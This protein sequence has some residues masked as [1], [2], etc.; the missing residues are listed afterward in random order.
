M[1]GHDLLHLALRPMRVSAAKR[2]RRYR[3]RHREQY[4]AYSKKRMELR[5]D[6]WRKGGKYYEAR[7][8]KPG[9]HDYMASWQRNFRAK[10]RRK[11]EG[12][13]NRA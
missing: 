9:Y 11:N 3:K 5:A 12:A 8:R 2:A 10:Q 7:I 4:R 13:N 1:I 6:F